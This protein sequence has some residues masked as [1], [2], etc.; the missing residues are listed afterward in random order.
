MRLALLVTLLALAA[1]AVAH[2]APP[3]PVTWCGTDEVTA[4]RVP[5]LDVSAA[6]QVR[7]VYAVPADAPDKFAATASGI[8]T[9]AAWIDSWWQTQ[10]PTRTPRFDKYA[11]P[12]CAPG[13]GQ[14]DIGFVRLPNPAFYYQVPQTPSLRLDRD[15]QQLFPANEKTI[16]Y[17]D[18]P[19]RDKQVCGETDYLA[20][21]QGG[22][23]GAVYIYLQ[24][25]CNVGAAGAGG[26]AEVAAHELLHNLGAVPDGAPHECPSSASHACDST[27]DIMY[28]Y[29][30]D[31]STLD[32]VQLD[33]GHDD[34][35]AHSGSWWDVQDSSW[36]THLPLYP[37]SLTVTGNGTLIAR[38]GG[39]ARIA[40]CNS[41]CSNV[42]I[43]NGT[44]ISVIAV[45]KPGYRFAGWSGACGGKSAACMVAVNAETSATAAF[46]KAALRVTVAVS[47]KGRVSSSP[48]G[49]TCAGTCT[50]VFAATSVKL[51]AKPSP[52]SKFAGWSG[53]CSGKRAT[54][55]VT[56]PGTARARFSLR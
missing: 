43:D 23:Q 54:C 19:I 55:A 34:Y 10:D 11:F 50:K 25:G 29:I 15:F 35:Y 31:G 13:F 42:P 39:N 47:G 20:N 7:F 21:T 44:Q 8:A 36:L 56:K 27:T 30:T 38:P 37:F 48:A 1:P 53:A 4:N 26:T 40:A 18:S 28:P 45:P 22:A 33:V 12:G 32:T 16:V 9:D 46:V 49:L 6:Q 41:G 52:G 17:F 3:A 5:D 24:S 14:L 51:T 2:A